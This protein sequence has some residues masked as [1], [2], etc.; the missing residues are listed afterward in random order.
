MD[1]AAFRRL[2]RKCDPRISPCC[3]WKPVEIGGAGHK[4]PASPA[5]SA[6]INGFGRFTGCDILRAVSSSAFLVGLEGLGQRGRPQ[7]ASGGGRIQSALRPDSVAICAFPVPCV[8]PR[9]GCR[10][11]ASFSGSLAGTGERLQRNAEFFSLAPLSSFGAERFRHAPWRCRPR[12]GAPEARW[13]SCRRS[14]TA[15]WI[16]FAAPRKSQPR[17]PADREPSMRFGLPAGG[18]EPFHL[19]D[20]VGD[21]GGDRRSKWPLCRHTARSAL[22]SFQCPASAMASLRYAL[23]QVA[24]GG[25]AHRCDGRPPFLAEFSGE[26]LFSASANADRGSRWPWPS[27]APVVVLDAPWCGKF[28]G[29]PGGQRSQLAEALELVERPWSALPVRYSS[30]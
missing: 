4:T 25:P 14:A 28:S 11:R 30:A 10:L 5:R 27:R 24:V 7:H 17:S 29:W 12:V 15:C 22:L 21:R 2:G 16:S 6:S 23:H 1:E 8:P 18:L 20:R 3:C 9:R 19:V 13:W 26:H